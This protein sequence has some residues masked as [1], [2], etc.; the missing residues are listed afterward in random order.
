MRSYLII[1]L[2]FITS[3]AFGADRNEKIRL[4][5]D[6]QGTSEF[7]EQELASFRENRRHDIKI[8]NEEIM[9]EINPSA[10]FKKKFDD[11]GA[12]Y[13]RLTESPW[14]MQDKVNAWA[15]Y[16]GENFSD[17]E[18]DQLLAFYTSSVA[19]KDVIFSQKARKDIRNYFRGL[20][21]PII[22]NATKAYVNRI[23][24]LAKECDCRTKS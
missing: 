4:L 6:A 7:F 11:A 18:I 20:F 23:T 19:K 21:L 10:V 9:K 24:Q 22:E 15:K 13:I 2:C 16:Y 3:T 17:E 12:D 14:T 8:A 1:L 5:L